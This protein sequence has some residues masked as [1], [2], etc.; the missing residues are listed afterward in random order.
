MWQY[1]ARLGSRGPHHLVLLSPPSLLPPSLSSPLLYPPACRHTASPTHQPAPP[2]TPPPAAGAPCP[3]C[4]PPVPV[5]PGSPT[6]P[7]PGAQAACVSP[8]A[9]ARWCCL[10]WP[11]NGQ[12]LGRGGG[13]R[14][15]EEGRNTAHMGSVPLGEQTHRCV[16]WPRAEGYCPA[17]LQVA[18]GARGQ[19]QP[20]PP[21][22]IHL[23]PN[24]P[25]RSTHTHP[26]V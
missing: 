12:H 18:V 9:A 23:T 1:G 25:D 4:P 3:R 6:R 21:P 10:H 5:L 2:H 16:A 8:P 15:E 14:Q 13:G 19:A 22:T 7:P 24:T 20:P 17:H 11:T 26:Q